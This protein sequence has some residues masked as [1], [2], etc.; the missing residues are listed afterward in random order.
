MH[1][2][3]VIRRKGAKVITIPS[4]ATVADLL[5]LLTEHGIG[6]VVVSD[7]D[8]ASVAG[9]V[10]ERDIVRSLHTEGAGILAASVATIMTR[11]VET[12]RPEDD[13]EALGRQMTEHRVRHVPVV[14]EGR[15]YAIVSIGDIVKHRIDELEMERDQLVGY[16]H[17]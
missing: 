16:I 15:L 1:I 14:V 6:A 11:G 5:T 3:E 2:S 7:D 12:C 4:R 9:I 13:L 10:S 17:Q 8:G